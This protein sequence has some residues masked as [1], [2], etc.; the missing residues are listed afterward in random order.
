MAAETY[1]PAEVTFA[2]RPIADVFAVTL[3]NPDSDDPHGS[4]TT[5]NPLD[6]D[7]RGGPLLVIG[8]RDGKRWRVTLPEIEVI[9]RS[10]VG[11]EFLIFGPIERVAL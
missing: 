9:R 4:M 6:E 1:L 8:T 2:A 11:F 10:A 5:H 3:H 7:E